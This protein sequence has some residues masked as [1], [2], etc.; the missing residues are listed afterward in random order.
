MGLSV[1]L[2]LQLS[3]IRF[4]FLALSFSIADFPATG[5]LWW[6]FPNGATG[7]YIGGR[8]RRSVSELGLREGKGRV[9][10]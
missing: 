2:G 5:G 7:H 9:V 4:H 8:E 3:R 6:S 10:L 1:R